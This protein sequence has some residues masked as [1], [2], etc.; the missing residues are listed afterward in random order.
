MNYIAPFNKLNGPHLSGLLI[1]TR[2]VFDIKLDRRI[3]YNYMG[4]HLTPLVYRAN[5]IEPLRTAMMRDVQGF[6]I[7]FNLTLT[8]PFTRV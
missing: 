5:Q 6:H 4:R 2:T 3:I 8:K 7:S 1:N